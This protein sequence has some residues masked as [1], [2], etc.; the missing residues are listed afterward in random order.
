VENVSELAHDV[1]QNKVLAAI[2]CTKELQHEGMIVLPQT[3]N[4]VFGMKWEYHIELVHKKSKVVEPRC[5]GCKVTIVIIAPVQGA[6]IKAYL[7]KEFFVCHC[8]VITV[9]LAK[10]TPIA[11]EK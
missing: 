9:R 5:F 8:Q 11:K 10:K 7:D 3:L 2:P 4:T 6:A 1:Q